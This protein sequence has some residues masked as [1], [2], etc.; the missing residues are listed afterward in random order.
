MRSNDLQP[1]HIFFYQLGIARLIRHGMW[2]SDAVQVMQ[3]V[4]PK[5]CGSLP[6]DWEDSYY[7]VTR[8]ALKHDIVP[9][10]NYKPI[11]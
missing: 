1:N 6:A 8:S 10:P 3:L 5:A 11:W 7:Y 2:F 9:I 4:F